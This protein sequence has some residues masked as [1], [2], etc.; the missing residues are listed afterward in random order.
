M[1]LKLKDQYRIR[2]EEDFAIIFDRR[3]EKIQKKLNRISLLEYELLKLFNGKY[4]KL[5]ICNLISKNVEPNLVNEYLDAFCQKYQK[6]LVEC[7]KEDIRTD[8]IV[9]KDYFKKENYASNLRL[10]T[11]LFISLVLTKNCTSYCK[12]CFS[13]SNQPN[14]Q[15]VFLDTKDIVR[16]I[17]ECKRLGI[18]NINLTGGDPFSHPEIIEIL[19]EVINSE[20]DF[21]IST[22]KILSDSEIKQLKNIGLKELQISLDS[23][24]NEIASYLTGVK[25]YYV[26]MKQVISK[27]LKDGIK[28]KVNSV[29]TSYNIETIPKLIKD[30]DEIGVKTLFLTPCN[31]SLGRHDDLFFPTFLQYRNLNHY[32]SAYQGNI[33]IDYQSP[34]LFSDKKQL[35]DI[36]SCSGG[37]MGLVIYP[38]GNT[39]I[40]ERIF[41]NKFSVGNIKKEMILNIWQG[42]ALTKLI[43]PERKNFLNSKCYDCEN[44]NLCIYKKGLCFARA[45]MINDNYWSN[46]PLC[47]KDAAYYRFS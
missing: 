22:K 7:T 35:S 45:K 11:P 20:I 3:T 6:Y 38:D 28:V 5:E 41:D 24:N 46:D 16:L 32:L 25:D 2:K 47:P 29:L 17:D 34:R 43:E 42:E 9:K 26:K 37:R 36:Q 40:C 23:S 13:D 19:K 31:N 21:N 30:L 8:I 44:Y 39:S 12:Y 15:S 10:S 1:R 33:K 27:L 4:T 18:A 14:V